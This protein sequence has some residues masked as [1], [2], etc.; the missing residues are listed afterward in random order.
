MCGDRLRELKPVWHPAVTAFSDTV[1]V[2]PRCL[3]NILVAARF[4]WHENGA[5]ACNQLGTP[6]VSGNPVFIRD[7]KVRKSHGIACAEGHQV[8]L[9]GMADGP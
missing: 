8:R 5:E 7:A 2:G 4:R 9:E 6:C 1:D 3:T